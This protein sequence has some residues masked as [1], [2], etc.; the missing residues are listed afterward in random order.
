MEDLS[1]FSSLSVS[2]AR[3]SSALEPLPSASNCV[4]GYARYGTLWSQYD[5]LD[6]ATISRLE[7]AILY[8][9]LRAFKRSRAIYNA[10]PADLRHHPVVAIEQAMMHWLEWRLLDAAERLEASLHWAQE[11]GK[12]INTPGIYTLLRIVLAKVEIFTK[13]DFT[14]AR[15]SM[16]ELMAW[17]AKTPVEHYTDVQYYA[18][19]LICPHVNDTMDL[20]F[21]FCIPYVPQH[22]GGLSISQLRQNLQRQGRLKEARLMLDME[23]CFLPS[24]DTKQDACRSLLHAC[25]G[26]SIHEPT[27]FVES[28]ARLQLAQILKKTGQPLN[29][30]EEFDLARKLLQ[31]APVPAS[32]NRGELSIKL[33]ELET[34]SYSEPSLCL[35]DWVSFLES[36]LVLEDSRMKS[37]ALCK[38]ADAALE[39][40][41]KHTDDSNRQIFWQWQ[42]KADSMLEELGDIYFLFLGFIYTRSSAH[43]MYDEFAKILE[44]HEAFDAKYPKFT[45]WEIKIAGIRNKQLIYA[46]LNDEENT[47]KLL[48]EF[49]E[50]LRR[51]D[52]FWNGDENIIEAPQPT[53]RQDISQKVGYAFPVDRLHDSFFS[54]WVGGLLIPENVDQRAILGS[55]TAEDWSTSFLATLLEWLQISYKTGE[56]GEDELKTILIPSKERNGFDV[57]ALLQQLTPKGLYIR[58]LDSSHWRE[59]FP[60]LSNWLI[61]RS[62][63]SEAKRHYLLGNIQTQKLWKTL[64]STDED[65]FTEAQRMLDLIPTLCEEVQSHLKAGTV[66]WRNVVC[67]AKTAIYARQNK[68]TLLNEES[69]QFREIQALYEISLRESQER[70]HHWNEASTALAMA[71]HLMFA[72]SMLRP[73]A[74]EAFCR[75][76]DT[77]E[78]AFQKNRESWKV[79]RG[80]NK[81]QKLLLAVRENNRQNLPPLGI[82]VFLNL[83]D[84]LQVQRAESTWLMIQMAKSFGLGWLMQTNSQGQ[85]EKT[86]SNEEPLKFEPVPAIEPKDLEAITEDTG[87]EVVYV[88]WYNCSAI[89]EFMPYTLVVTRSSGRTPQVAHVTMEWAQITKIVEELIN[90]TEEDLLQNYAKR[91]LYKLNPLVEP[92]ASITKP[93]QVLVF[94][95]TGNLGRIP[96]HALRIDKEVLIRR[97]PV[98]YCNSMTV[99]NVAF[100][101]RK[102]HEQK[103]FATDHVFKASLFGE[104]PTKAGQEALASLAEQ[105]STSA[106]VGDRFNS[107]HFA[108]AIRDPDLELFHYHSHALFENT[109]TESHALTFSHDDHVNLRGVFDLAPLPNSYHATLLGCGSGLSNVT[110]NDDVVGLVSA[111]LYSGAASTVSAL[112]SFSDSDAAAYSRRFYGEFEAAKVAQ[113]GGRVD[114]AR[115]NQKAVLAIMAEKPALYHW[116]PFVLNGYWMLRVRSG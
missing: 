97:N 16:K 113:A 91:K 10:F 93:G 71:Q 6:D 37:T 111:F 80:W 44:W 41:Q 8:S 84:A 79:L 88:D 62:K 35:Q 39:I 38:I 98:V 14:K 65:R 115:A 107:S 99:L 46:R 3:T 33:A 2:S 63:Y 67:S 9:E 32:L 92:L 112:W 58:I 114:L 4:S 68:E 78:M 26:S 53:S 5:S 108:T 31:Q 116:A 28:K 66:N 43:N 104:P 87:S 105:F 13:S 77:A 81:V 40:L 52:A 15:D 24:P 25:Q 64:E 102:S 106:H 29:A 51:R 85:V 75:Y 49:T 72:A 21:L 30:D 23:L 90:Y 101:A 19:I 48:Q 27:W 83:P 57:S 18:L 17:L 55:N 11:N 82:Q 95:A 69:P 59:A 100:Q 61:K 47:M 109:D 74:F 94:C 89:N 70:N 45:L 1:R 22:N 12:D 36:P 42:S 73:A 50:L 110:K 86:F 76:L 96:L 103:R 60:I 34:N 54:E 56:L 20:D 7:R